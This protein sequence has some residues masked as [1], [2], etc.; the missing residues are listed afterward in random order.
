MKRINI[1]YLIIILLFIFVFVF[2][3]VL[4]LFKKTIVSPPTKTP[5]TTTVSPSPIPSF[6][7]RRTFQVVRYFPVQGE[8]LYY[9]TTQPLEFLFSDVVSPN[10]LKYKI[11]PN[12]KMA[13]KQG[14]APNSLILYPESQWIKGLTKTTITSETKATDGAILYPPFEYTINTADVPIPQV[15]EKSE[16]NY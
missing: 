6:I 2:I 10:D 12:T 9:I 1:F 5:P 14:S 13:V 8:N 3:A 7:N 11:E 16:Q 4:S 15:E